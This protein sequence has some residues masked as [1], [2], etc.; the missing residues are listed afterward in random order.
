MAI[1][2]TLQTLTGSIS[3]TASANWTGYAAPAAGDTI[4]LAGAATI[5]TGFLNTATLASLQVPMTFTGTAG[6][7]V[8]SQAVKSISGITRSSST[9]TATSTAHGYSN[10]DVVTVSGATQ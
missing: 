4:I 1:T 3:W 9:A 7:A 10:G 5:D 8:S 6:L 2:S